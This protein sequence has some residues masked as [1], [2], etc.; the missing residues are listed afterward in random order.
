MSEPKESWAKKLDLFAFTPVPTGEDYSSKRSQY[1]TLAFLLIYLAYI[2]YTLYAFFAQNLPRINQFSNRLDDSVQYPAPSMAF[3][4]LTGDNLNQS[5]YDPTYFTFNFQQVTVNSNPNI[6]RNYTTI[7]MA[8]CNPDWLN[9]AFPVYCPIQSSY[10][11]GLLYGSPVNMYPRMKVTLC[12]NA[13][14]NNSCANNETINWTLMTGRLFVFL[15]QYDT[16]D[17]VTG[18]NVTDDTP[19]TSYYYF[20]LMDQYNRAEVKIQAEDVTINPDLLITWTNTQMQRL[21]I[22]KQNFYV[23]Q[24]PVVNSHDLFVWWCSMQDTSLVTT[25]GY[26]TSLDYLSDAAAMWALLFAGFAL[27]FLRFNQSRYYDEKPHMANF[28]D[29]ITPLVVS[30]ESPLTDMSARQSLV[31]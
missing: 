24:V 30:T 26:Q 16:Y 5:F 14:T 4:F 8:V 22:A 23:S 25:V 18:E 9:P 27:Y 17:Y 10:V 7:P 3:A 13:T 2:G 15:R 21:A 29:K 31:K 12:N 28:D 1:A 11:Q 19:F 6:P 20:I